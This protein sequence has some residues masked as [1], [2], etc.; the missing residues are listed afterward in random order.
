M[1]E[2]KTS[3]G[4]QKLINL[5][6]RGGIKFEREV[7]FDDLTGKRKVPLRFDFG[8]YKNGRLI[9]LVEFDGRQHYEY[10]PYFHKT[11]SGYKRQ[12]EWDRRKNKYCLMHGI[13]L[14]RVPYWDL[15]ILTLNRVLTEPS[16]IVRDK[17]HIDNLKRQGVR[18]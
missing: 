18:K 14:I 12:Q 6:R 13:P 2:I 9:C 17:Y 10:V 7:C 3:K 15:D 16:Y 1:S 4:E 5:F 11:I 8:L